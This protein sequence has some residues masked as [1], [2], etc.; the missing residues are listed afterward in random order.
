MQMHHFEAPRR[1]GDPAGASPPAAAEP[2][3]ARGCAVS[4]ESHSAASRA[5]GSR[6]QV[7]QA[8]D[9]PGAVDL[10]GATPLDVVTR[11]T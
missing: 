1:S 10:G 3:R 9:E 6:I 8:F 11:E 4:P 5:R 7:G 2:P